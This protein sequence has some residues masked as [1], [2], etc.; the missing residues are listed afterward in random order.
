MP[1]C[2]NS[3][4]RSLP[5]SATAIRIPDGDHAAETGLSNSPVPLPDA[6]SV[7]TWAP[8]TALSNCTRSLPASAT[9]IR[10]PSG[11]H[12]AE[13][14]LSNSAVPSPDAPSVRT[15]APVG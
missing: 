15:W 5:A 11:D 3:W 4:M 7:R 14:G 2:R 10:M 6:P 9:A 8:V 1:S 12:A 13:T